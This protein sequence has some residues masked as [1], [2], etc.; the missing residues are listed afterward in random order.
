M[1]HNDEEFVEELLSHPR[2][3]F[4]ALQS[5]PASIIPIAKRRTS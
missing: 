4:Y 1:I 5:E 2:L 3:P